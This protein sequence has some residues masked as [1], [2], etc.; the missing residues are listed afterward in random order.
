MHMNILLDQNGKSLLAMAYS[1]ASL[2]RQDNYSFS[3]VERRID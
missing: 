1:K 3:K 2:N